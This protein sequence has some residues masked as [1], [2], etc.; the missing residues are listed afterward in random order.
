[1]N[2]AIFTLL[3]FVA[4]SS[5]F[6]QK[7]AEQKKEKS[8]NPIFEGWYADPEAAIFRKK[9]WIYPTYSAPYNEQIHLDAFSSP[10]LVTWTKHN[11]IIDSSAVKW[12]QKALWAPSVVEKGG[13]YY[14]FFGLMIFTTPKK[15]REEL[16]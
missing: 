4:T 3:L 5:V 8:D 9:Y 1:M 14:L 2:N 11:R 12:V 6:A 15:K 10:D 13:K 16:V 7:K